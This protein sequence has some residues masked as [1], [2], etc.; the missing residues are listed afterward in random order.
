MFVTDYDGTLADD[1]SVVSPQTLTQLKR[2]GEKGILRV[3]ATG[4]SLFSLKTVV[5]SDF[6]IDYLVFSSGIGV[7]DWRNGVLLQ[8]NVIEKEK[9]AEIYDYLVQNNYDFM[10][11]L[12]VP[13]NHFFHHF[14]SGNPGSDFLTRIKYYESRGVSTILK[15]PETASQFVVIC[16]EESDH[17]QKIS[18][19]FTCVKVIRATSPLDRKSVWIEILPFGVSKASGIRFLQNRYDIKLENIVSVGNDFYDL[20]MLTYTNPEN[21]FIVENAPEEIRSEFNTIESNLNNGVA[22]LME[23]L[24]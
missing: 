23:K 17:L 20:D 1:N 4:R 22:K 6:P 12:P 24:Y 3:L 16:A 14:S 2:L 19:K 11:Q 18:K 5:K 9:T 8:E 13:D 7:Y 15:C 21:S 10:V